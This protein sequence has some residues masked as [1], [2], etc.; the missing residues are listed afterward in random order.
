M[1]TRA[2][3]ERRKRFAEFLDRKYNEWAAKQRGLSSRSLTKWAKSLGVPTG[4]LSHYMNE[5]RN[6]TGAVI[7]Q[8]A[9][10]LGPEVLEILEL[11]P[12]LPNDPEVIALVLW[13][14]N[15][16]TNDTAKSTVLKMVMKDQER[17]KVVQGE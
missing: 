8:L 4:N 13:F 15:P 6:P 2:D 9:A 16:K 5:N 17:L 1:P 12:P 10:A 14:M 11:P 7:Y 3:K